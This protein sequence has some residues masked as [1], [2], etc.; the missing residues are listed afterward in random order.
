MS[1]TSDLAARIDQV[2]TSVKEK[3]KK[4]QQGMLQ[5]HLQRQQ[6][7]KA[8]EKV[9]DTIIE[10]VKPRLETFAKRAGERVTVTPSVSQYRRTGRFEFRSPKAYI[11]LSFSV[12]PDRDVKEAVIEYDVKIVP[13]LWKFDSH[14]EFRT[15]I[16]SPDMTALAKWVDD[17]IL[18]FVEL[19]VEINESEI[20]DKAEIV[21]DPVA[22]V[23]FP[24]FAAGAALE[25][26][27]Q[28]YYFI[29]D[30]TKAQFAKQKGV[31]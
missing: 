25:H 11:T 17:R 9:Q 6:A 21:E 1:D 27:G 8:Y 19:F 20:V 13:V 31:S 30:T 15:P 16:A 2:M 7:L 28:T 5:D 12:G 22:K 29:D 23:K 14:L 10:V 4:Q 3:A 26:G 18:G 24:R